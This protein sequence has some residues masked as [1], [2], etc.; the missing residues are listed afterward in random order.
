MNPDRKITE[1]D[2]EDGSLLEAAVTAFNNERTEEHLINILTI[3]R[4]SYVWIPCTAVISEEDH[5]HLNDIAQK[6][7]DNPDMDPTELIGMEFRTEGI[8]RMIPDILQN[9]DL[10]FFPVFST[11]E[12]M[13]EY[14]HHFSKVQRHMLEAISLAEHNERELAGIVLNAFTEPFV[15]DSRIFDIVKK[16]KSRIAE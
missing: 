3:L 13:G 12:A 9:G 6:L 16:M 5:N 2:L 1:A 4:D 10:Y 11:V 8:T 15:L 7:K 14:G